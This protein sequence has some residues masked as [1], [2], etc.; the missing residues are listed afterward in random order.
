M[1]PGALARAALEHSVRA[2][3]LLDKRVAA[4]QRSARAV[5]DDLVSANLSKI[6][7][8]HLGGKGTPPFATTKT[9]FEEIRSVAERCFSDLHLADDPFKWSVEGERY[10]R[11]T[12]EAFPIRA[13]A[14]GSQQQS[15]GLMHGA[16]LMHS[17][18]LPSIRAPCTVG[19]RMGD[20]SFMDPPWYWSTIVLAKGSVRLTSCRTG[21]FNR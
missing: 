7:V 3:L 18:E 8:S 14:C 19:V 15:A 6:A 13:F 12:D 5:L 4:R 2:A 21:D 17:D 10:L 11:I 16:G 9:R 20:T 1:A